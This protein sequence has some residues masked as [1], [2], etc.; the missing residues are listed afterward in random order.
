MNKPVFSDKSRYIVGFGLVEMAISTNPKLT[1]YRT[2]D[3]NTG[4][5]PRSQTPQITVLNY[6]LLTLRREN[7]FVS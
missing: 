6:F 5:K 4:P 3:E 1:I 2:L 7:Y